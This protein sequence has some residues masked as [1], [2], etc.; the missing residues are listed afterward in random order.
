MHDTAL[1]RSDVQLH[2]EVPVAALVSIVAG[3]LKLGF[4]PDVNPAPAE[5]ACS[6]LLEA[7]TIGV[8]APIHAEHPRFLVIHNVRSLHDN[9]PHKTP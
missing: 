9:S 6:L 2:P 3:V 5:E 7:F 4:V 8:R 1:I